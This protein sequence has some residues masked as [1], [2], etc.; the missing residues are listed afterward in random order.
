M[1]MRLASPLPAYCS[2]CFN[3]SPKLRY[4]DFDAAWDGPV[5][6]DPATSTAVIWPAGVASC[7]DDLYLCESCVAQA[8]EILALKPEL[9]D[10]QRREIRRL[11]LENEHWREYA[12]E[13]ERTLQERPEPAPGRKVLA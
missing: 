11:Q 8:T 7:N 12:S 2:A 1:S 13:L 10:R 4:V 9:N 6:I 3:S 5:V